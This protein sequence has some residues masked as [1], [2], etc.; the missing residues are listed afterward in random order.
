MRAFS[1]RFFSISIRSRRGLSTSLSVATVPPSF[2]PYTVL[3]ARIGLL[4]FCSSIKFWKMSKLRWG[5]RLPLTQ[6]HQRITAWG[7]GQENWR[8]LT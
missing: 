2:F 3:V 6:G 8:A 4:R 1:R 5:H 7:L